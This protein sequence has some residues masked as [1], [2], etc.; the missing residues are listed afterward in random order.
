MT[1]AVTNGSLVDGTTYYY[2]AVLAGYNDY[3]GN[4]TVSSANPSVNF[5]MTAKA[6]YSYTVKAVDGSSNDLGT[7][8]SGSGYADESVTYYY[9]EFVLSGTTLYRKNQN[10]TNPYWGAS[11]TLDANNKE[12]TVAY[13]NT[14][15]ENVVF[16]KEAENIDGFTAKTTNNATIRCSAGTGGISTSAVALTTLLPGKY[17]IF[18]QV[19]GTT[20]LTATVKAG[21][22]TVWELASTGSLTSTTSAEFV[23]LTSTDLTVVT[24]GGNDNRMLDLVYIVRT[25]DATVS[26]TI[27]DAKYATYCSPYALDFSGVPGLK[28]YIAVKNGSDIEFTQVSDVPANTGVL[29]KGDAGNYAIP[30]IA[31]STTDVDDNE[32]VGVTQE[33]EVV[34]DG[35]YV[36][37]D[38]D[39]GVGFYKTT[40]A[41]TVGANTAYLPATVAN[42]ARKFIAF[43]G[44]GATAIK[45][46]KSQQKG[47]DIYNLQGQRVKAAKRGLY[48]VNGK[49]VI[50]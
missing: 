38:G 11:G 43:D 29:L 1:S 15:I 26:R 39:R 18:G 30:V 2:K 27:S 7:V 31:E 19:W 17:T 10:S 48:I 46:V 13:G 35:I 8:G 50:K 37:L 49:K 28:A 33:P 3:T 5:T 4:F 9:P 34:A 16:Y 45:S 14:P 32:F 40:T 23:L 25:G 36:L 12:F 21:D 41:F 42:A 22:N 6:I 20:G 44:N 24:T 47:S